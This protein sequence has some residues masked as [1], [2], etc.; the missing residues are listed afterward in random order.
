MTVKKVLLQPDPQPPQPDFKR[1]FQAWFEV[2]GKTMEDVHKMIGSGA[3]S[4]ASASE[5]RS[6]RRSGGSSGFQPGA[7]APLCSEG[8]EHGAGSQAGADAT[9][10]PPDS[11][12]EAAEVDLEND[13]EQEEMGMNEA[14]AGEASDSSLLSEIPD[15]QIVKRK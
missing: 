3:C 13:S 10:S 8:E 12:A 7:V 1:K 9:P 2:E 15:S 5:G 11:Q 14:E 6:S 4:S